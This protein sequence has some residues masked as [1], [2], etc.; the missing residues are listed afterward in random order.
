[1]TIRQ[2][3]FLENIEPENIDTVAI[4]DGMTELQALDKSPNIKTCSDLADHFIRRIN[5]K[6]SNYSCLHLIFDSYVEDSLK[7]FTRE[8]RRTNVERIHYRI[9]PETNI[10]S[11]TKQKLLSH[12]KTK[13]ELT[14]FLAERFLEN[15][16]ANNRNVVI[17]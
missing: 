11:A 14:H 4:I 13:D 1:M 17:A 16:A 2:Q 5:N 9:E 12:E 7:Q 15:A 10:Y 8:R 3:F 6:Y